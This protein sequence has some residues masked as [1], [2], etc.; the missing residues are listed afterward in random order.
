MR[1]LVVLFVSA[2]LA[3]APFV[4]ACGSAVNSHVSVLPTAP[5]ARYRTFSFESGEGAPG[6]Y[7]TSA[8]SAG[9][10]SRMKPLITAALEKKGYSQAPGKGDFV[11]RFGSGRRDASVER[12]EPSP[13]LSSFMEEDETQD[14]VEGALVID[15]FDGSN[16]G[17]IWH[18]SART[19]INPGHVDDALLAKSV[20]EV[21]AKFPA[22]AGGASASGAAPP[23]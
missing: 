11:I 20:D 5:F 9:I 19:E 10:Q 18:G 17:Q 21:L 8:A 1:P 15:A 4:T 22:A 6:G 7:K 2:A 13:H 14:F 23:Q 12:H 16:D 3:S